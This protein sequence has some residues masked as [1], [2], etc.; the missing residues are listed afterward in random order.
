MPKTSHSAWRHDSSRLCDV[1]AYQATT[2]LEALSA[3][4]ATAGG[5]VLEVMIGES[6]A[7]VRVTRAETAYGS[8][9]I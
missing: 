7:N 4:A 2:A 1:P 5:A 6:G 3:A 8:A 9:A